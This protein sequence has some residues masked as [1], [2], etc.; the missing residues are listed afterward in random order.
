MKNKSFDVFRFFAYERNLGT[1]KSKYEARFEL[2][3]KTAY[4][5]RFKSCRAQGGTILNDDPPS[6]GQFSHKPKSVQDGVKKS[7]TCSFRSPRECAI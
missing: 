2:S 6:V 5:D 7:G 4:V 3:V 1:L